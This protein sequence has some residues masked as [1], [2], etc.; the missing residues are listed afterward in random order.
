VADP[1][2]AT[3]RFAALVDALSGEP[4][5]ALG[6]GRRGFGSGTLMVGGRIF[7][8]VADDR[9]VVK[10]AAGRVATL[11]ATGRGHPFGAGKLVPLREWT[12]L[13]ESAGDW[14]ELAREALAFVRSSRA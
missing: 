1:T 12:G 5:V 3:D 10:L 8:M 7:A 14:A 13:D 6:H 9:L 4:G 11:I 2:L